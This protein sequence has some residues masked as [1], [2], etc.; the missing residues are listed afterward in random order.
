MEHLEGSPIVAASVLPPCTAAQLNEIDPQAW[1]ADVLAR[2]AEHPASQL[3][4][5]LPW[6]WRPNGSSRQPSGLKD[7]TPAEIST[8]IA[9]RSRIRESKPS[10]SFQVAN[11][12][13]HR[14]NT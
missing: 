6:T 11:V 7:C 2:N 9:D 12:R 4:D 3:G 14:L 1:L 8:Q 13:L 5:L 10:L